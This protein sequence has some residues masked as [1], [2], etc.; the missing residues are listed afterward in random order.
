MNITVPDSSP[1]CAFC[2]S[3]IKHLHMK[4]E[5]QEVPSAYK[6]YII[7]IKNSKETMKA[8]GIKEV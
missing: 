7:Q 4:T 6:Y 1:L 2:F 3:V 5:R 8:W